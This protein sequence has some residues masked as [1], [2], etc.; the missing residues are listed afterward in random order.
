MSFERGGALMSSRCPTRGRWFARLAAGIGGAA[1]GGVLLSAAVVPASANEGRHIPATLMADSACAVPSTANDGVLVTVKHAA[2]ARHV[3]ARVRL[4]TYEAAWV[5]SHANNLR[6][7]DRD[8][9]GVFQQRPS[10]GWGTPAQILNVTYATNKF[11]DRA[12]PIAAAHSSWSAGHVAQAVQVSAYP[13][14][15]DQSA[16]KA[17]S[18]ISRAAA[19]DHGSSAWPVVRSGEK[20]TRV[21]AIQLLL[22]H[23]GYSLAA[24]GDFG[25]ITRGNVIRFQ[26]KQGLAQDGVVGSRTWSALVST[27]RYGSHGYHV[28][29]VQSELRASGYHLSVDGKFGPATRSAVRSFQGKHGLAVDGVVGPN[30]WRTLVRLH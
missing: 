7:G 18:L 17:R 16:T 15:Y 10:A 26:L 5:E 3:T 2:D 8:S 12:I 11:L 29:A 25:P 20:S 30:T 6:C 23:R 1:L 14:R 4:A 28:R 21:Q 19:L 22:K 27:A 13:D 24:D 9:L